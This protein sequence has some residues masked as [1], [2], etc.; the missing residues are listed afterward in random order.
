MRKQ[1]IFSENFSK[2]FRTKVSQNG[3]LFVSLQHEESI[4]T[5]NYPQICL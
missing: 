4:N 3:K 2:N 1:I 5:E